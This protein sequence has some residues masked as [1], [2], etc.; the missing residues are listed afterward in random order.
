MALLDKKGLKWEE[1]VQ[2]GSVQGSKNLSE[3]EKAVFKTAFEIDQFWIIEHAKM[4]QEFICQGQSV[5]LFI[6][7]GYSRTQFSKLHMY[8]WES[9]LKT[10]YYCRVDP[11]TQASIST[12]EGCVACEG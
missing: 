3:M 5:N 9:K 11:K 2:D 4:R 10:L 12:K 6:G 8:A 1:E 7:R